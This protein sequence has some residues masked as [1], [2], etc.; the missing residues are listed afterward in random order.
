MFLPLNVSVLCSFFLIF[1]L[2]YVWLYQ[3]YGIMIWLITYVKWNDYH[4]KFSEHPSSHRYKK[5]KQISPLMKTRR[6]YS[7]VVLQ[8]GSRWSVSTHA[9]VWSCLNLWP[10]GLQPTRLL[11]PWDFPGKNTGADCHFL[12]QG[13]FFFFFKLKYNNV[14]L[15]SAVLQS[16]SVI[17]VYSLIF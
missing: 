10:H 9:H 13:L 8:R 17:H 15:I 3:V 2:R 4:S 11:C 5:K 1:L 16:G 12:L 14:V 6:I 7:S